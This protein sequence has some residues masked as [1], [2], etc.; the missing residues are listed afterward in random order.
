MFTRRK[1]C[2]WRQ[3]ALFEMLASR[4]KV[5]VLARAASSIYI[6]YR[7]QRPSRAHIGILGCRK[8]SLFLTADSA[9]PRNGI[10]F[11]RRL[12]E[13]QNLRAERDESQIKAENGPILP[14]KYRP[15]A[16]YAIHPLSDESVKDLQAI[17]K[18][19]L[20]TLGTLGRVY[21]TAENGGINAQLSVPVDK[22]TELTSFFDGLKEFQGVGF[23]YNYGIQD[24]LQ[25]SF[26]KLKVM[27]K[28]KVW[29]FEK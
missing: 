22:V 18:S 23:E 24:T 19:G 29:A 28:K 21:I 27:V 4:P 6:P 2:G 25:P 13:T 12:L 15:V 16:F 8:T 20:A 7:C 5:W 26:R 9:R 11:T 1:Y 14:P 17:I 3:F 10:L